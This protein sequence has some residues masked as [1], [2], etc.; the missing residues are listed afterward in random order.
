MDIFNERTKH[1]NIALFAALAGCIFMVV[2]PDIALLSA[3]KGIVLW[4]G[5]IL[6]ALLPFFIC[7]GFMNSLGITEYL[8]RGLF[9]FTMSVLAGYPM[10]ARIIGDMMRKGEIDLYTARRL[11]SF[12][13]TS[14]PTFLLG[15][16][17]S[18]M[19]G[20]HKAGIVIALSH[21]AG[22]LAT[23]AVFCGALNF[24]PLCGNKANR[25]KHKSGKNSAAKSTH[26][27]SRQTRYENFRTSQQDV[28]T[29][30]TDSILGALKSLGI[31]LAYIVMF[32]FIT[33]LVQFSGILN[34]FPEP[35]MKAVFKGLFEMTVGCSAVSK[36][37]V[38]I[39]L[40]TILCT[41]LVS[42]GGIS[43]IGQS[44][45]MLA[46]SGVGSPY[47]ISV[48]LCHGLSAALIAA[49]LLHFIAV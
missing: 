30:L 7:V 20:S 11:I 44:L 12:C 43:V 35:Y 36:M 28:F 24:L 5:S 1:T 25:M 9:V 42:F 41:F 29:L 27:H 34:I 19:L 46:G 22:A 33:D 37:L 47:F 21:Y 15:A 26:I 10:G 40:K 3:Q 4:A 6:P 17:G 23:G 31:V 48:K 49:F 14:G 38:S 16:V 8:P 45:S 2:L 32:M 13:S 18:G 39:N